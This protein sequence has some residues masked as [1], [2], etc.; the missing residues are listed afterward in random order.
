LRLTPLIGSSL[1]SCLSNF[2]TDAD[3]CFAIV[4][5]LVISSFNFSLVGATLKPV[6]VVFFRI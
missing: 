2:P 3:D 6:L 1:G 5:A 4:N